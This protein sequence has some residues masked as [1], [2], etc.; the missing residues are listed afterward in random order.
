M[1]H[2]YCLSDS[3]WAVIEPLLPN[4]KGGTRRVD[5]RRVISG[6]IYVLKV[7]CCWCDCPAVHRKRCFSP[8]L[9]LPDGSAM[10]SSY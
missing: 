5:D 9:L 8:T 4:S 6:I 3:Q 7:G 2:L 1:G 10:R